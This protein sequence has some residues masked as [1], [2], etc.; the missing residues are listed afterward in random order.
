MEKMVRLERNKSNTKRESTTNKRNM[1]KNEER[2]VWDLDKPLHRRNKNKISNREG[3]GGK[4]HFDFVC[5][6]EREGEAEIII[7]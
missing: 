3:D 7:S 5:E 4:R 2:I 1:E 6:N